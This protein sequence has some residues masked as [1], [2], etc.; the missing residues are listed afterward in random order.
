MRRPEDTALALSYVDGCLAP[1]AIA[2]FERRLAD[3]GEL[4]SDVELWKTQNDLIRRAFAR[5][6]KVGD[7]PVFLGSSANRDRPSSR[8]APERMAENVTPFPM[9]ARHVDGRAAVALRSPPILLHALAVASLAVVLALVGV[10]SPSPRD[11]G[12]RA[13]A[14][15]AWR[16]YLGAAIRPPVAASDSLRASTRLDA[17]LAGAFTIPGGHGPARVAFDVDDSGRLFLALVSPADAPASRDAGLAALEGGMSAQWSDGRRWITVFGESDATATA[18]E[19]VR[20]R[21]PP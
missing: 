18:A 4:K 9:R 2:D 3:D 15:A 8:R 5:R 6:A 19:A 13:E 20:L 10:N 14:A 11:G 21:S 1:S 16:T 7:A 12:L 17:L